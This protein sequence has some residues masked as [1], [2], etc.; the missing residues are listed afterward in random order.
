M[1]CAA[2]LNPETV[3]GP[4][5]PTDRFAA[6]ARQIVGKPDS[7]ALWAEANRLSLPNQRQ[8]F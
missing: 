1:G 3:A 2:V 6:G 4:D 7:Y 8:V 5:K